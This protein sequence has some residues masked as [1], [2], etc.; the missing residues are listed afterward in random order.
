M[1][2]L[3]ALAFRETQL[4]AGLLLFSLIIAIGLLVRFYLDKLRL[5]LIPR[6]ATILSIVVIIMMSF[7]VIT[8]QLNLGNGLSIALFPIVIITMTIERMSLVWDER[9]PQEEEFLEQH[10]FTPQP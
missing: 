1:P 10:L 8:Y 5:L 2:V 3:V 7:S 9:S 4:I 6:I